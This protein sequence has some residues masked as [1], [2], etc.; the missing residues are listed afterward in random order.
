MGVVNEL[1]D[2]GVSLRDDSGS[3][4]L[5]IEVIIDSFCGQHLVQ[6]AFINTV[7]PEPL[8]SDRDQGTALFFESLESDL[9]L[10]KIAFG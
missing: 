10:L 3:G 4:R 9:S 1:P 8:A 2:I 6:L 7:K 5:Y